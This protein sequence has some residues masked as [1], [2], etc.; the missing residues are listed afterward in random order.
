MA[1]NIPGFSTGKY[2]RDLNNGLISMA[3]NIPGF[4]FHK[5]LKAR[6]MLV[7]I[8]QGVLD[9]RRARN[10][11]GRDPINEKKGVIDLFMEVEDEKG[12]KLVDEDIV[13]LLLL[14]L[15]AG[16]ESSASAVTWATIFLHDNPD[17]LQK[18]KEEQEE[19]LRR[20][21]SGQKGLNLKEIRQM[22]Y[23]SKV[24]KE[25]LRMINL[26]FANFRVAKADANI[27]GI[28]FDS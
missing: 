7:K 19:I 1:I 22:E 26:L 27:N 13:N 23:L 10:K 6:K 8:V 5:A 11:I 12:Q 18:A 3:I 9:E 28:V 20:R 16:H 25:T 4:S 21:P 14:F 24:I 15:V 17:T 2:Y